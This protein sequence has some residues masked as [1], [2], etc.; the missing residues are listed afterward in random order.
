MEKINIVRQAQSV[1]VKKDN[2]TLVDYFLFDEYEIHHNIMPPNCIQDWHYHAKIEEVILVTKGTMKVY[3]R[4]EETYHQTLFAG[5]L[6]Q[7]KDTM[8]TFCNE[9]KKMA[10][11]IVFRLVLDGRSKKKMIKNDKVLEKNTR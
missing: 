1:H 2:K 9:S 11:F 6:V 5:D 3:W 7:V 8:H 10:E 4:G